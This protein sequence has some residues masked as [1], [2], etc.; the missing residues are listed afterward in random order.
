VEQEGGRDTAA[1]EQSVLPCSLNGDVLVDDTEAAFDVMPVSVG[2][3]T[4]ASFS[5]NIIV[6]PRHRMTRI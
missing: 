4:K 6:P 2:L 5:L 3:P 1:D